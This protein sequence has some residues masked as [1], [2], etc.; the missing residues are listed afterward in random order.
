MPRPVRKLYV[1]VRTS[2]G[3]L[4]VAVPVGAITPEQARI[5]SEIEAL[6]LELDALGR[7]TTA[8]P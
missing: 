3:R 7:F 5:F 6:A 1:E 4:R 8:S 2:R